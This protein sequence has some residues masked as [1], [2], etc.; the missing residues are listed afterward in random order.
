MQ[1]IIITATLAALA[2]SNPVVAA[3]LQEAE[4]DD[5]LV[6]EDDLDSLMDDSD[7]MS[8]A[9]DMI[10]VPDPY[11]YS[12]VRAYAFR[13]E[14]YVDYEVYVGYLPDTCLTAV[15][16]SRSRVARWL[17]AAQGFD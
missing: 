9:L 11:L 7:Y 13:E 2:L 14:R 6:Q 8:H 3:V 10:E 15:V 17:A 12:D 16:V 5:L 4:A 1:K